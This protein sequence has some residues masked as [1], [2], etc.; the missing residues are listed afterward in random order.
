MLISE[1]VSSKRTNEGGDCVHCNGDS[2]NGSIVEN[3]FL[4][5]LVCLAG[6]MKVS[7]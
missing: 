2:T 5:E 4:K 3:V 7:K 6:M 1:W